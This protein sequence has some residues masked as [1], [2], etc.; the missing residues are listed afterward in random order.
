VEWNS[1]LQ[2]NGVPDLEPRSKLTF[3][4][5]NEVVA[6]A[7]AGQGVGLGRRPLLDGLLRAKQLVAPFGDARETAKAYFI[8]TDAAAR[9]RPAVRALEDWLRAEATRA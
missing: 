8:V 6:A 1:W 4:S 9:T 2:A 7:V 3:S 5:Y